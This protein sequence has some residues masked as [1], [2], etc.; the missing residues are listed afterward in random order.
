VARRRTAAPP[1]ARSVEVL[2]D[3]AGALTA[4]G[5]AFAAAPAYK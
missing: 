1:E 4:L 2:V 3:A 5:A